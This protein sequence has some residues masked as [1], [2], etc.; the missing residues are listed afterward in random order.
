MSRIIIQ[1]MLDKK[2]I[3]ISGANITSGGPLTI[4]NDALKEFS[5]ISDFNIVAIVNNDTLFYKANNIRF[6]SIPTYKKFIFL[7]FY[8]EY[9]VYNKISRKI[10]PAIWISLN[11]FTPNVVV[12]RLFT[13]FHNASIF[14]NINF[15]DYL[16]S[17]SIIFQKM[18]YSIFLRFNLFKNTKFIV[19][20]NWIGKK[21]H[22]KYTLPLNKLLIFKP[23]VVNNNIDRD[24]KIFEISEKKTND[25]I[26]FYPT[27][28]IGYKNIELICDALIILSDMYSIKN[29]ELRITI[30]ENQN[31]YSKFIKKKYNKLR[32]VWLGSISR[33][34]V[35]YNYSETSILVYPSRLETWGLPLSEFT[36]YNK[37]ILAIDLE[38]VYE[39]VYN[40]PYVVFFKA[41]KP[42]ELALLIKALIT[43]NK[44]NYFDFSKCSINNEINSISSWKELLDVH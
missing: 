37:P 4:Y 18:Y 43:K 24:F 29:I 12:E 33:E 13:Y 1:N 32:I 31:N 23:F 17:R 34:E 15:S 36:K 19:Q 11:D 5:G 10:K 3:V 16:F 2:T 42:N 22:K 35:E 30:N 39:T 9:I 41:N 14:F 25:F 26:L 7:K 44:M 21:I 38:Y 8:Y 27:R 28:A 40:Y 20:Q 6:I